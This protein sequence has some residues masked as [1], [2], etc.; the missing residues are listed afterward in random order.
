MPGPRALS[1][2]EDHRALAQLVVPELLAGFPVRASEAACQTLNLSLLSALY[3][4]PPTEAN[5]VITAKLA[6]PRLGAM[7]RI[8]WMVAALPYVQSAAESLTAFVGKSERRASA[9][10]LALEYQGNLTRTDRNLEPATI[11]LLLATLMSITPP[12]STSRQ[13][14]V[15]IADQRARLVSA[16][17]QRLAADACPSASD[18]LARLKLSNQLGGWRD[19]VVY[20]ASSQQAVAREV[21]YRAASPHEV[22]RTIAD[23]QPANHA[24]L[25][26][27]VMQHLS[28]INRRLRGENTSLWRQF[29]KETD[30][31]WLPHEE[32]YC[33]D[34]LVDKLKDRLSSLN[35]DV[36][37]EEGKADD[38]RVD[39]SASFMQASRRIS[40]PIEVKKEGHDKLWTAWRDQLQRLYMIDPSAGGYG[41]YLVLWFGHAPR[42]WEGVK[43]GSAGE[44]ATMLGEMI[45]EHERHQLKVQVLDLSMPDGEKWVK[46]LKPYTTP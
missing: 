27:L 2:D 1:T 38:K 17:L 30:Q 10:G 42:K 19:A 24:D 4:L 36:A 22:A 18:A 12:Q 43:P 5:R 9:L 21:N 44:L 7:Q 29:W 25:L 41:L 34:L 16:L 39:M 13:G 3:V 32:E 8:C 11:S 33:R 37:R 31:G 46:K 23:A 15:T 28:D 40:L 45:P 35:I 26:A 14:K 20:S 6:D